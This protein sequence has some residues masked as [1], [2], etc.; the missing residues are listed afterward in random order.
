M[1]TQIYNSSPRDRNRKRRWMRHLFYKRFPQDATRLLPMAACEHLRVR[2]AWMR[3]PLHRIPIARWSRHILYKLWAICS[4][5]V[6]YRLHRQ[7]ASKTPCRGAAVHY[8][9]GVIT[10]NSPTTLPLV[11]QAERHYGSLNPRES[12][13][14][15]GGIAAQ[16]K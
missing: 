2:T 16:L 10:H 3:T 6:I 5:T 1:L 4:Y 7:S 12:Q 11:V 15:G 14:R 13:R 9:L 8:A